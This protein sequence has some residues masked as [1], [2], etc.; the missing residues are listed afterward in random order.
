VQVDMFNITEALVLEL[1]GY[2]PHAAPRA[3]GRRVQHDAGAG[4]GA[5]G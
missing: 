2:V 5:A 3:A 4:A 1:P